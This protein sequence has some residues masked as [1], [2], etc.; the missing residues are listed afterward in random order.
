MIVGVAECDICDDSVIEFVEI[1]HWR[2]RDD[3]DCLRDVGVVSLLAVGGTDSRHGG[4][5]TETLIAG[6]SVEASQNE[7]SSVPHLSES[8]GGRPNVDRFKQVKRSG[9]PR[10]DV[11]RVASVE[12][13]RNGGAA[14]V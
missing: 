5:G 11:P 9:F 8:V 6:R 1:L 3:A 2:R 12:E 14:V 13:L 7:H 10:H 4:D